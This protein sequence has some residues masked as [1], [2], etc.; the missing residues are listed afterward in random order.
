MVIDLAR[1]EASRPATGGETIRL[2]P[3]TRYDQLSGALDVAGRSRLSRMPNR[4]WPLNPTCLPA[5]GL[6]DLRH[7]RDQWRAL[8]RRLGREWGRSEKVSSLRGCSMRRQSTTTAWLTELYRVVPTRLP[9][10]GYDITST[11]DSW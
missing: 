3:G 4:R 9:R 6:L 8:S 2:D 7:S 10:R 11:R 1:G 5:K